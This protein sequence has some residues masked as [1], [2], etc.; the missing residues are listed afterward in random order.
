VDLLTLHTGG[1]T[2]GHGVRLRLNCSNDPGLWAHEFAHV[3]QYERLGMEQFLRQ[4]ILQISEH[5]YLGAPLEVDA[6]AK[7]LKAC[8]D[9]GF[10]RLP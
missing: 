1:L 4:Y 5:G 8:R 9:A 3:E 10:K 6:D 7:A 2:A